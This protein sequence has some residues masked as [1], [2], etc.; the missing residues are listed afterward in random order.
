MLARLLHRWAV[1][2]SLRA[3]IDLINSSSEI[4][5]YQR[6]LAVF[7]CMIRQTARAFQTRA[8]RCRCFTNRATSSISSGAKI[9]TTCIGNVFS[10]VA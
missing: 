7:C 8:G 3:W 5:V 1:Q 10:A 9:H 2:Q 4:S 6:E